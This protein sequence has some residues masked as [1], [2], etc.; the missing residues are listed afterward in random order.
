VLESLRHQL[1]AG[2]NYRYGSF[3]VQI[4]NRYIK[5]ELNDAYNIVDGRI[6]YE[7]HSVLFYANVSNMFDAQYKEAGAV[8]MPGKWFTLGLK[9]NWKKK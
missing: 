3:N 9:Y 8:P 4:E 2:V 7:I 6:S 1:I 5:R